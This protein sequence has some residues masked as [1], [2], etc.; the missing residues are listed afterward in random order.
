[1]DSLIDVM[2]RI[3]LLGVDLS[4]EKVIQEADGHYETIEDCTRYHEQETVEAEVWVEDQ[5]R[6][7]EPD[8]ERGEAARAELKKIFESS[9]WSCARYAAGCL[10]GIGNEL[11]QQAGSCLNELENRLS[12]A[13]NPEERYNVEEDLGG[14]YETRAAKFWHDSYDIQARASGVRRR[15]GKL[16]GIDEADILGHELLIDKRLGQTFEEG[17]VQRVYDSA[18]VPKYRELASELLGIKK[19]DYLARELHLGEKLEPAKL[20]QVY[21]SATNSQDRRLAAELL[22]YSRVRFLAHEHPITTLAVVGT[23]SA[24]GIAGVAFSLGYIVGECLFK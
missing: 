8:I 3:E 1:M 15:A 11:E 16:L 5:P 2:Q 23:L 10:L 22:G 19:G 13:T 21:D 12:A 17:Q 14:F 18:Q 20:K 6:I 7:T 9:E 4:M 24:I